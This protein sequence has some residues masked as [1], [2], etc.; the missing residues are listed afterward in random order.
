MHDVPREP[1]LFASGLLADHRREIA[2]RKGTRRL[3]CYWQA[4][5]GR[6]WFRDKDDI[7]GWAPDSGVI[8][9]VLTL[10]TFGLDLVCG[11]V[12]CGFVLCD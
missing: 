8:E 5:S 11:L 10:A 2:T 3:G 9:V 6:V 12:T 4:L 7:P 1:I